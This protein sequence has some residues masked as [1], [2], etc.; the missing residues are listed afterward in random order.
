MADFDYKALDREGKEVS[1]AVDAPHEAQAYERLRERGLAPLSI[2]EKAPATAL[3]FS[4]SLRKKDMVRWVRQLATLLTAGVPLLEAIESL[5]RSQAHPGLS[6]RAQGVR[7]VLRA[8]GKLSQ[9]IEGHFPTLPP[10]VARLAELGEATGQIG[11]AL[12]EA[13]DQLEYE[14]RI[15]GEFRSALMYPTFLISIGTIIVLLMFFF[16]VPRFATLIEQSRAE[17]PAISRIVINSG[18]WLTQ[19]WMI[20]LAALVGAIGIMVL[21]ARQARGGMAGFIETLPVLSKFQAT[22]ELATW[23]R[24]L[25]GALTHGAELLKA[26]DLAEKGVRAPRMK[27]GLQA[28]RS[29]IRAGKPLDEA[30]D[31][32]VR[33]IDRVVIDMIRTGRT[34]GKLGQMLLYAARQYD[35]DMRERTKRLTTLAEPIAIVAISLIVGTI[36]ISIVLAMTSLYEV[37]P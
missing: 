33:G 17:V 14:E 32:H 8:G 26:F 16:V 31:E 2:K 6:E 15:A 13:A 28:A 27:R 3:R 21:L 19:N 24:T 36:V 1:G 29:A 22:G 12:T 34:S 18:V 7:R 25:G 23:S 11:P 10:Y 4:R 37:E 9:A 30:L 20:A 5:S 35:N